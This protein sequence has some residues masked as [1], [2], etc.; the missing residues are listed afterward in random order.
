MNV[1]EGSDIPPPE[2]GGP[3]YRND[4]EAAA[5]LL[6]PYLDGE[7]S[8]AEASHVEAHVASCPRCREALDLHRRIGAA[9]DDVCAARESRMDPALSETVRRRAIAAVRL[10]RICW[11]GAAAA[12]LLVVGLIASS[13]VPNGNGVP[14]PEDLI[15]NLEVLEDLSE[16][17]VEPSPELV[18]CLLQAYGEDG[19]PPWLEAE[20]IDDVVLEEEVLLENL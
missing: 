20:A 13:F 5:L 2:M 15:A 1:R 9:L 11:M 3:G 14:P 6:V 17:G 4:C 8:P 16:E 12:V 19:P 18:Q 10:R 7:V